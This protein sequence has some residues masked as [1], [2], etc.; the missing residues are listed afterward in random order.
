MTTGNAEVLDDA[1]AGR[2]STA[3][4]EAPEKASRMHM[5][6]EER[7]IQAVFFRGPLLHAPDDRWTSEE[8]QKTA[9]DSLRCAIS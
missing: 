6:H 1:A 4:L 2:Y 8:R 7:K 9:G 5:L 3:A